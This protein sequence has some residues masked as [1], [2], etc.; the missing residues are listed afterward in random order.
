MTICDDCL[1]ILE[2]DLSQEAIAVLNKVELFNE[3]S[4]RDLVRKLSLNPKH[5][6]K[7]LYELE[8]K[9]F[10]TY[11]SYGRT[12]AYHLTENGSR[13][14][15]L[16]KGKRAV[17]MGL[18]VEN[19]ANSEQDSN[20]EQDNDNSLE[21]EKKQKVKEIK[22]EMDR[23]DDL[24]QRDKEEEKKVKETVTQKKSEEE[25]KKDNQEQKKDNQEQNQDDKEQSADSKSEN[26]VWDFK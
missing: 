7:L 11:D 4:E 12:K 6:K 9:L 15:R 5:L 22:E 17:D 19:S 20:N 16:K 8:A 13:L 3:L 26:L 18:K 24:E 23:E 21:E 1:R 14:L 2:E 25:Q 10:L